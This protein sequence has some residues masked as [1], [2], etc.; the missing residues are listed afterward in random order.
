MSSGDTRSRVLNGEFYAQ[1]T[2]AVK[3][4]AFIYRLFH[5]DFSSIAGIN[6]GSIYNSGINTVLIP[7][8]GEISS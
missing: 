2:S 3:S 5:E 1:K 6:T 8:I 7:M 4:S